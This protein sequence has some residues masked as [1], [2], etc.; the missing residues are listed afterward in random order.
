M[1]CAYAVF[2]RGACVY[3]VERNNDDVSS[4][5]LVSTAQYEHMAKEALAQ[6]PARSDA[7]RRQQSFTTQEVP[8]R[9]P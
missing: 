2:Y 6:P 1:L 9:R 3:A 7:L 8:R 4:I 5:E